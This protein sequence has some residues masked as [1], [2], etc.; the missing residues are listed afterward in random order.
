MALVEVVSELFN[1]NNVRILGTVNKPLFV[2]SDIGLILGIQKITATMSDYDN[3]KKCSGMVQTPTGIREM[4]LLTERGL[5]AILFTSRKPEAKLFQSWVFDVVERIRLTGRYDTKDDTDERNQQ[6]IQQLE[7][8][9]EALRLSEAANVTLR[10][11]VAS[12]TPAVETKQE[13]MEGFQE[14]DINDYTNQPCVY[15]LHL[16]A[17]DYKFGVSGEIDVRIATH[18]CDFRKDGYELRTV[19]LWKCDTMQIMKDTE[20]KI[21]LLAKQRNILVNK[22]GKKEII[23]T[24]NIGYIVEC[25]DKYVTEP[26]SDSTRIR[27]LEITAELERMRISL[28][29]RK[30]DVEMK[31]LEIEHDRMKQTSAHIDTKTIEFVAEVVPAPPIAPIVQAIPAPVAPIVPN[32]TVRDAAVKW[33]G[34]NLPSDK[35]SAVVYFN[36]YKRANRECVGRGEFD[37]HVENLG[38]RRIT[39]KVKCW[40]K[41]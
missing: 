24:D 34:E 26:C 16:T 10:G 21:K 22:Y 18:I 32:N 40:V 2:A 33:I 28:E 29:M 1:G 12:L 17:N 41:R 5:Y 38:H 8:A 7:A 13:R 25:I 19:K 23:T 11:Q 14:F 36:R 3:T 15:L 20:A 39:D 27:E 4:T 9:N 31:R 37:Q 30:F 6:I 35:L